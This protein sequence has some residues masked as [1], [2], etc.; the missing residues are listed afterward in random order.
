MR[1]SLRTRGRNCLR[2]PA[3]PRWRLSWRTPS[4]GCGLGR[5]TLARRTSGTDVLT[6]QSGWLRMV[7]R[8]C[9][10]AKRMRRDGSGTGTRVS[11]RF[12]SLLFL[13]GEELYRQPRAV[14]K[15]W[16]QVTSLCPCLISSSSLRWTV[17]GASLQFLCS[18][19][20]RYTTETDTHSFK[21]CIMDWIDMPVVVHDK[22]VDISGVAQTHFP[23]SV[24]PEILQ[25][26][27][28]DK[29]IDVCCAGPW[30]AFIVGDSRDPTVAA[31]FS[32][33]QVVDIPVVFNDRLGVKVQKTKL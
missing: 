24:F 30:C 16:A 6:V 7:S 4:S 31:R 18:W 8:S 22:V 5:E 26:Q 23:W 17:D 33:G 13:L 12:S 19:V 32:S 29:V 10:T 1:R 11:P 2:T 21:L 27:Y 3:H 25:L 28:I 9:G 14:Y 20:C 15:Y